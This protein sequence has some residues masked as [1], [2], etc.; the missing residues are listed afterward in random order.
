MMKGDATAATIPA[1]IFKQADMVMLQMNGYG[2]GSA[3]GEG[4]PLPRIQTKTSLMAMLG[5]KHMAEM[6]G[7]G[8]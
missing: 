3:L 1:G 7:M 5:G 4:Q 2:P 8:E 6:G